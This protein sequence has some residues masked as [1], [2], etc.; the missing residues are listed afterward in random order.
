MFLC[1][2]FIVMAGVLGSQCTS[3]LVSFTRIRK[4]YVEDQADKH[5]E[6]AEKAEPLYAKSS[7]ALAGIQLGQIA[8]LT[9]FGVAVWF[10]GLLA[11]ETAVLAGL[12]L[13]WKLFIA[14]RLILLVLALWLYWIFTIQLPCARALADPLTVLE[15][16]VWFIHFIRK[17]FSPLS[18]AG[19]S[20]ARGILHSEGK[21]YTD[22]V[23]FTYNEDEIRCI[24]EESH[25]SGRLNALENML[26]KNSFDFFDLDVRDLMIPRS[27]MVMLDY[28]S[29]MESMRSVISRSH[30]TR[31]PIYMDDKDHIVGFIH[32]KDFMESFLKGA[33][34][35]KPILKDIL[36][37]PEVMP[38]PN[39]LQMMRNRRTYLA[40]VMDEYGGTVGM[41]TM[42]DIV[43]ELVGENPEETEQ[44]APL[45]VKHPDGTYE[46]DGMV[47]LDDITELLSI[48]FEESGPNTIGGHIFA[49]LERI[50]HVGDSMTI[51]EWKFTVTRMEG[52]RITRLRAEHVPEK[53]E[54]EK[55][56][57]SNESVSKTDH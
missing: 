5:P 26:I 28:D 16:S 13:D 23:N 19:V 49:L 45:I 56:D 30:H 4:K 25:S 44:E 37:V 24:V 6:L 21:K 36:F 48:P 22:E 35:I 9:I 46:F 20:A 55:E 2:I 31:Y 42:E 3:A 14:L 1:L 39:L 51:G 15:N 57:D 47:I 12:N 43:E 34:N 38:A 40:V 53:P 29:S 54:K 17:L 8:S 33:K 10:F 41:V 52:F 18:V 11:Q 50:P 32:V 7:Y 27:Q